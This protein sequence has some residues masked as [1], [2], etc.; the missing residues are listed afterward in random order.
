MNTVLT[1]EWKSS[2][3]DAGS[4][5]G[6]ESHI[7]HPDQMLQEVN[8]LGQWPPPHI[9]GIHPGPNLISIMIN[10]LL[11]VFNFH[12]YSFIIVFIG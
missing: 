7:G 11:S 3:V 12:F 8:E 4:D 2:K 6:K 9:S 10:I 5:M 1:E